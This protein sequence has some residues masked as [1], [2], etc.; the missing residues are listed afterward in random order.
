MWLAGRRE[1]MERFEVFLEDGDG[2]QLGTIVA[3]QKN[4]L[5]QQ[6]RTVACIRDVWPNEKIGLRLLPQWMEFKLL[7][8]VEHFLTYT[9]NLDSKILVDLYEPYIKSGVATRVH[10]NKEVEGDS[11]HFHDFLQPSLLEDCL[12]RFKNHATCILPSIDIDEYINMKDGNLFEGGRVPEDYVGSSWDAI[13]ENSGLQADRVHSIAF[14]IY[15]FAQIQAE[16]VELLSVLREPIVQPTCPKYVWNAMWTPS[17]FIGRRVGRMAR[18]VWRWWTKTCWSFITTDGLWSMKAKSSKPQCHRC[19][20]DPRCST[21]FPDVLGSRS[22]AARFR[23]RPASWAACGGATVQPRCGSTV[24]SDWCLCS[25][26]KI[27]PQLALHALIR[28]P[29]S[30]SNC[31]DHSLV[32]EVQKK[33]FLHFLLTKVWRVWYMSLRLTPN[34]LCARSLP[35]K[36]YDCQ[37]VLFGGNLTSF[38]REKNGKQSHFVLSRHLTPWRWRGLMP[39]ASQ[40]IWR[41]LW[42][43]LGRSVM[44]WDWRQ[45]MPASEVPPEVEASASKLALWS[46][47][48]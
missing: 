10:F 36:S 41:Q 47:R 30:V 5:L 15:R 34:F 33:E 12:Y 46:T 31:T 39:F 45:A 26:E 48:I 20:D 9:V 3:E 23:K 2:K 43:L 40:I 44:N 7:H 37:W 21:T 16:Q 35:T 1:K 18:R 4:G 14:N 38:P 24:T 6:Y 17:M 13:V 11:Q 29:N 25:L 27:P 8:G 19:L 28:H 22:L 32:R 42:S